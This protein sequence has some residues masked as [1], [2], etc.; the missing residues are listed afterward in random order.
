MNTQTHVGPL[1]KFSACFHPVPPTS[2]GS[3]TCWWDPQ[4][5]LGMPLTPCPSPNYTTGRQVHL[6][7]KQSQRHLQTQTHI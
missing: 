5:T 7:A 3:G 4:D 1:T 2:Q 6:R